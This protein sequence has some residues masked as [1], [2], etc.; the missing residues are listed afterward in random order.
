MRSRLLLASVASATALLCAF[1]TLGQTSKAPAT[2]PYL[3]SAKAGGVNF[4]SGN[5]NVVRS[6]GISGVLLEGDEI[7]VGDRVTTD[8][9]GKAEILLNP[10][11]YLRIGGNTSFHFISTDLENLKLSLQSGSAIL[12]VLAADEFK[13]VVKL[14][15]SALQ[16]TRSGVFRLDVLSDGSAKL[17]TFKGK[18]YLGAT[19]STEVG[20]G[21]VASIFNGGLSVSKFDRDTNDPLDLWSKERGKDLT[22][23]NAKLQ[24]APLSN[25]LI[26]SFNQRGWGLYNSF[27]LWVFDPVRR[28]W[29]FL[30]FG[31]GWSSPYGWAYDY[32]LWRCRLP[33]YVYNQPWYPP[34]GGGP[35]GGGGTTATPSVNEE[36][37]VRMHTPPFQRME[38]SQSAAE[39]S[40]IRRP[41]RSETPSSSPNFPS[42]T[43]STSSP[44]II[45]MP[46]VSSPPPMKSGEV[47]KGKP[48]N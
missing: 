35:T 43:P 8:M 38:T 3:I 24:R 45:T 15:H 28:M 22:R 12:E 31:Y 25:S 20:A 47:T 46:T 26:S 7:S 21:R 19:G 27:G 40:V 37:R 34:V 14:P 41:E 36:R 1:V 32:D 18:A 17:S 44:P 30:P 39:T 13:V 10:G 48:D 23:L 6:S 33:N 29:C 9:T 5:V 4:V 16:L 42:S 2:S 11:S